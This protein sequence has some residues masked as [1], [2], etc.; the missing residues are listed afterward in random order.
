MRFPRFP[1]YPW[2][3]LGAAV[4]A[5]GS[6]LVLSSAEAPVVPRGVNRDSSA[7]AESSKGA[8]PAIKQAPHLLPS[9][10]ARERLGTAGSDKAARLAVRPRLVETYGKLPLS[11]EINQG[12]TDSQ[13]KFLSRGPGYTLFLTGS[14]AVLSLESQKSGVRSQHSAPGNW[15]LETGNGK[16]ETG[17]SKLENRGPLESNR[18]LQRAKDNGPRTAGALFAPLIQNPKSQIQNPKSN[19]PIPEARHSSLGTRHSAAVLRLRLV[20]A[21]PNARVTGLDPLPGKS[22]YFI[23]ND[24]KKWRTNVSNYAK[25]KVEDV[26]PGIDLVYYGRESEV[27]NQEPEVRSQK[28]GVRSQEAQVRSQEGAARLGK[29]AANWNTTLWFPPAP[30]LTRS[31]CRSKLGTRNWK[32][33]TRKSKM[34]KRPP[35]VPSRESRVPVVSALTPTATSSSQPTP[36]KSVSASRLFINRVPSPE[37]RFS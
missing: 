7:V 9:A 6:F 30:T 20:G 27:R 22:N 31:R 2:Y 3:G 14:E 29:A 17:K 36:A 13:V 15:K 18:Q 8:A 35:R 28:S 37:P 5:L 23:G 16:F 33:E 32:L 21:D 12:Q 24:P 25:V 11:F 34:V 19:A 26:Y 1:T 4:L 10:S